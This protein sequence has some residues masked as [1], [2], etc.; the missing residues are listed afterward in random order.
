MLA[1]LY[2]MEKFRYYAFGKP[3]VVES[4]QKPLDVIFRKHRASVP[5][6]IA[7]V[8][9]RIQKYD[10]Q[11]KYVPGK[12]I[13]VSSYHSGVVQELYVSV[14]KVFLH[15]NASPARLGH[16]QE[17]TAKDLTLSAFA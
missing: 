4:D 14:H 6:H 1:V 15:L 7:K 8:V 3:A 9:L 12:D 16:I 10:A 2:G 17:K 13:P 5:P 11:I